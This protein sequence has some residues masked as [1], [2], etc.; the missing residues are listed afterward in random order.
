MTSVADFVFYRIRYGQQKATQAGRVRPHI[1]RDNRP[2]GRW[3]RGA[4]P[5]VRDRGSGARIVGGSV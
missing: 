3:L 4:L 1:P 5:D 2:V